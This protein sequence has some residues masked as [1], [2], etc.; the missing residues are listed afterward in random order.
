[1]SGTFYLGCLLGVV[2][3]T[4]FGTIM[5]QIQNERKKVGGHKK[6]MSVSHKTSKTPEEI[7]REHQAAVFNIILW[8]V[9]GAM[10]AAIPLFF[11][12]LV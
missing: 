1:M 12:N 6:P 9:L 11:I 8:V 2:I 7:V 5:N 3:T 10:L 4:V